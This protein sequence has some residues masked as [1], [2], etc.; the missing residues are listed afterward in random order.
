MD[1]RIK[2]LASSY[3]ASDDFVSREIFTKR[4]PANHFVTT[5]K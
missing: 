1:V 2:T 3:L 4:L 5:N